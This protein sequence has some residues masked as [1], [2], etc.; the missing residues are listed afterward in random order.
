MLR[1]VHYYRALY[2]PGGRWARAGA[3]PRP[4]SNSKKGRS[5]SIFYV[6]CMWAPGRGHHPTA[7][8]LWCVGMA[9]ACEGL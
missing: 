9:L 4:N 5:I 1:S 8:G 2:A 3:G 6:V 7:C